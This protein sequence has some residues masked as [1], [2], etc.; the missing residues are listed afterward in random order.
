MANWVTRLR[1]TS[2]NRVGDCWWTNGFCWLS[3]NE[4]LL[5]LVKINQTMFLPEHAD[6]ASFWRFL[7]DLKCLVTQWHI[8]CLS[9]RF[10]WYWPGLS[11][12]L[13]TGGISYLETA[14]LV[15]IF[16]GTYAYIHHEFTHFAHFSSRKHKLS[17][18]QGC[19]RTGIGGIRS[20]M[21][22]TLR[23]EVL[24]TKGNT[25]A[26]LSVFLSNYAVTG[27][28]PWSQ[29]LAIGPTLWLRMATL[30]AAYSTLIN[31]RNQAGKGK[32]PKP[33]LH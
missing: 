28:S 17:Y 22:L 13:H 18:Q 24:S 8:K 30:V 5:K 10:S 12:S 26:L 16:Q 31:T 9:F 29:S 1:F 4:W 33:T 14:L 6:M 32:V 3:D 7:N 23:H 11:I 15:H 21:S 2:I 20:C 19:T 25:C 27:S